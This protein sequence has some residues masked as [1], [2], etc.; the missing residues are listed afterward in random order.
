MNRR[1]RIVDISTQKP[2]DDKIFWL[3]EYLKAEKH[4]NAQDNWEELEIQAG[5]VIADTG[6]F[7]PEL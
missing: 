6:E 7:Q 2:I 1:Y 5:V 3:G 4:K